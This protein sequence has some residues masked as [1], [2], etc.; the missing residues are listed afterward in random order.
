M[1]PKQSWGDDY[2]GMPQPSWHR[3]TDDY[4]VEYAAPWCS[5]TCPYY[6]GRH[7]DHPMHGVGQHPSEP[8]EDCA[9]CLPT[10]AL[11]MR[12]R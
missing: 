1:K 6:V 9:I 5:M 10:V 8:C 2:R 12:A 4:R 11:H 7:C 3:D